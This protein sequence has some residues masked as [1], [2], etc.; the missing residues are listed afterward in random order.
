MNCMKS[1]AC[2]LPVVCLTCWQSYYYHQKCYSPVCAVVKG[3]CS[4]L[5]CTALQFFVHLALSVRTLD[6][7]ACLNLI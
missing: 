1:F 7:T 2:C 4:S 5:L 3:L 6:F